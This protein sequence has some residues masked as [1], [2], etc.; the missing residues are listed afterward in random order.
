[1]RHKSSALLF[2]PLLAMVAAGDVTPFPL[3]VGQCPQLKGDFP[4]GGSLENRRQL[5]YAQWVI[6][7]WGYRRKWSMIYAFGLVE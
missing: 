7:S 6:K 2:S 1:M 5:K 4:N 3:I